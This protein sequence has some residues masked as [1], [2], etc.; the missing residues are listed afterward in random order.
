MA[1]TQ[2]DYE[3]EIRDAAQRFLA[4]GAISPVVALATRAHGEIDDPGPFINGL[5]ALASELEMGALTPDEARSE[6]A[7]LVHEAT[8][9]PDDNSARVEYRATNAAA[10]ARRWGLGVMV[11]T[12]V[13]VTRGFPLKQSARLRWAV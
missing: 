7:T 9:V 2:Q 1:K 13:T 11:R 10:P 6:I 12:E 8:P 3:S 4:G 5:L